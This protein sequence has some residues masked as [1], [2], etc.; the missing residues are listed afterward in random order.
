MRITE[1]SRGVAA[2]RI[3]ANYQMGLGHERRQSELPGRVGEIISDINQRN[4]YQR[5]ADLLAEDERK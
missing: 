4:F 1:T 3:A 2:R 5:W